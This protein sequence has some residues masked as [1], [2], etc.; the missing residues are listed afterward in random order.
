MSMMS[1]ARLHRIGQPFQVDEVAV[2]EATASDVLVQVK[3]CGVVPNLKNV[4]TYFPVWFPDLPMPPLPA[5]FGLDPAGVVAA[6]GPEVHGVKVGQRVYVNPGRWCG[7]CVTCRSGRPLGCAGFA[8]S[9]YFGFGPDARTTVERY[10]WGGFAQYMVA[11]AYSLV[12]LPDSVAFEAAARFGYLGT[13]FAA[14]NKAGAGAQTTVLVNGASGTLGV[15]AVLLAL[16]MGV[17]RIL[18]VGR[19]RELLG[20]V[21]ALDP[22]RIETF[23]TED[24]STA[25]WARKLTEERGVDVVIEALGPEAPASQSLEAMKSLAH[26]GRMIGIGG[27]KEPLTF[28]PIWMLVNQSSYVGS[29]WFVGS[30]GRAMAAMAGAGT[31]NLSCFEHR[32]YQLAQVNEAVNEAVHGAGGGFRNVVIMP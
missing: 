23:S 4:V 6:V 13:A 16:A 12:E 11:P 7:T 3:A 17:P 28:D 15:G 8:F 27:M 24:G 30:E 9:G 20:R 25:V 31:L 29:N 14:L 26:G 22:L 21:K 5:I 32:R 2:P 19:N 1:A 18:G 10:P